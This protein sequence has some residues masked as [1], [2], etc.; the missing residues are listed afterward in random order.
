M[1]PEGRGQ[2]RNATPALTAL[3]RGG[4]TH[5]VHHIDHDPR[6]T[7]Y[8]REAAEALGVD[9]DRVFKT[10]VCAVK[11]RLVVAVVPVTG[12]LDLKALASTLGVKTADLADSGTAERATGYV[13]GGISPIGQKRRLPTLIDQ[14]VTRWDSVF[15]SGG[16][17]GL[18]IEL[19]PADLVAVTK[20]RLAAIG[21]TR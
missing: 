21:R 11:A 2:P 12:E 20:G 19:T 8:G 9:P 6:V 13:V 4:V 18:E 10:L 15:I 7:T 16:R 14:S 1:G 3:V 5:Q 17:R